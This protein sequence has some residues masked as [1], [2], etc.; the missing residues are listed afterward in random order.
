VIKIYEA[1]M[2]LDLISFLLKEQPRTFIIGS[3]VPVNQSE[4]LVDILKISKRA[5]HAY[6]IKSDQDN[7]IRLPKQ[8]ETYTSL[9]DYTSVVVSK[10]NYHKIIKEIPKK[11]GILVIDENHVVTIKRKATKILRLNKMGLTKL[12]WKNELINILQDKQIGTKKEL[13][14][15]SDVTLRQILVSILTTKELKN[16]SYKHLLTRYVYKY[17]NFMGNIGLELLKDDLLELSLKNQ[18]I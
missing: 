13:N 10:A 3:E 15:L 2:K 1:E 6:E 9:F 4:N 18:S 11:I 12:L 16:L 14:K 17:K 5:C 8:I 7:F